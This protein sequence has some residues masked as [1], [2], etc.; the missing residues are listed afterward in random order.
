M[1]LGW[2]GACHA[3]RVLVTVPIC[4]CGAQH[5]M[6]GRSRSQCEAI[7]YQQYLRR[8]DCGGRRRATEIR[9]LGRTPA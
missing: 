9:E 6:S 4:A 3:W 5:A 2:C 1:K 8:H 7:K